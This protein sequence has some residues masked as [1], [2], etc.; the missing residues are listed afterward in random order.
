M[1]GGKSAGAPSSGPEAYG[2]WTQQER[3]YVRANPDLEEAYKTGA[4]M[5]RPSSHYAESSQKGE[6]REGW[7]NW[8]DY[9]SSI[10]MQKQME[11]MMLGFGEMSMEAQQKMQEELDAQIAEQQRAYDIARLD[12]MW[13]QRV[14]YEKE[15]IESIDTMISGEESSAKMR[16]VE[17]EVKPENRDKMISNMLADLMPADLEAEISGL[18]GSLGVSGKYVSSYKLGEKGTFEKKK[19]EQKKQALA[20]AGA[21]S[22]IL[23]DNDDEVLGEVNIL[24]T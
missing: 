17:Y 4:Y 18:V 5:P 3:A 16:G 19:A 20:T 14:E 6:A 8:E 23:T 1:G 2:S 13:R 9:D 12:N 11:E 24:G 7:T 21:D 10:Q 15:A 22:T